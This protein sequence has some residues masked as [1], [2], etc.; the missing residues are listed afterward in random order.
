ML[1]RYLAAWTYSSVGLAKFLPV[2]QSGDQ[3]DNYEFGQ[4]GLKNGWTILRRIFAYVKDLPVEKKWELFEVW[5]KHDGT[6][7]IKN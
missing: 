7:D 3:A 2:I 6:D 5:A 4:I 1:K